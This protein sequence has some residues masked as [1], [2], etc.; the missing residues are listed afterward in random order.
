MNETD[1]LSPLSKLD[2]LSLEYNK[3][4]LSFTNFIMKNSVNKLGPLRISYSYSNIFYS[5]IL[6]D[7]K[8]ET[9]AA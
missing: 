1:F 5:L 9:I 8:T 2:Y 3:F 6:D 7:N 4:D